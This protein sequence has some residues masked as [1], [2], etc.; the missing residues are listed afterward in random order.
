MLELS[1]SWKATYPTAHAGVLVMHGVKN[2]P[3]HA[4]LKELK[5]ALEAELRS[6]YSGR[7][8]RILCTCSKTSDTRFL[9]L[10]HSSS[11][12][13]FHHAIPPAGISLKLRQAL[14]Q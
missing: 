9:L 5:E 12:Y 7:E 14:Q 8:D 11:P 3:H 4:G 1:D 10:H 6:R 13:F 2:P